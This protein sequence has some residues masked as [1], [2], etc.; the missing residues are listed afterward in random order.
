[1]VG[2]HGIHIQTR[3]RS[4][5]LGGC[6]AHRDPRICTPPEL[7]LPPLFA[8][9]A[10]SWLP[11]PRAT[12]L[13]GAVQPRGSGCQWTPRWPGQA[14]KRVLRAAVFMFLLQA[15]PLGELGTVGLPCT[16]GCLA[17]CRPLGRSAFAHWSPGVLCT[18]VSHVPLFLLGFCEDQSWPAGMEAEVLHGFQLLATVPPAHG[19][20]LRSLASRPVDSQRAAPLRGAL[21][22]CLCPGYTGHP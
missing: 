10:A 1:M 5:R 13:L 7:P 18:S 12:R 22:G 9:S 6:P 2:G 19:N 14:P 8:N 15:R 21:R 3:P 4:K 17:V 11:A 16:S 20:S